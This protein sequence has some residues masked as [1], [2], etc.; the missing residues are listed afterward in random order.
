MGDHDQK[1]TRGELEAQDGEPL[2]ARELMS[3]IDL[4]PA[5]MPIPKDPEIIPIDDPS[6]T[7]S[8]D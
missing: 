5:V 3:M 4:D 2:P 8:S 6:P 1:V 7:T